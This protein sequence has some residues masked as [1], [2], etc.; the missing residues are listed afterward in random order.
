VFA[1]GVVEAEALS[2]LLLVAVLVPFG[3]GAMQRCAVERSPSP[4]SW[5]VRTTGRVVPSLDMHRRWIWVFKLNKKMVWRSFAAMLAFQGV[6]PSYPLSSDFPPVEGLTPIQGVKW[7]SDA[8]PARSVH[9][10]RRGRDPEG[11]VC[12]FHFFLDLSVRVEL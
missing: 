5:F 1:G 8:P 3:G 4:C 12:N 6:G 9:R 2:V 10:R 7:S 11:L